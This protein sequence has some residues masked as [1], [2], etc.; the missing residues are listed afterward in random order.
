VERIGSQIHALLDEITAGRF[1]PEGFNAGE[2]PLVNLG[3]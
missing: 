2:K 3:V 1:I